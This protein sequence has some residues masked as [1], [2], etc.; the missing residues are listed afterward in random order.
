MTPQEKAQELVDYFM[1]IYSGKPSDYSRTEYPTAKLFAIK[2]CDEVIEAI[3]KYIPLNG[4]GNALFNNP[5]IEYWQEVK[6]EI[7]KL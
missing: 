3:P 2:L 1:N 4:Y 6:Q 7:E 5:D